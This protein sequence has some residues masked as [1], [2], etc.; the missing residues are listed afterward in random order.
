MKAKLLALGLALILFAAG[1][2]TGVVV[3]RSWLRDD[4]AAVDH[5]PH[6]GRSL[7][8]FRSRLH[9]SDQQAEAIGAILDQARSDMA[10]V[11]ESSQKQILELLTPEQAADYRVM[12]EHARK[13]RHMRGGHNRPHP[14]R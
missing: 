8:R 4:T 10:A 14:G 9:L 1:V 3:D 6:F 5:R 11:R 2:A 12:I 7:E 13:R